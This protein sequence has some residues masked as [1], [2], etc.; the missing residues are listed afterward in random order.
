MLPTFRSAVRRKLL[1]WYEKDKRDLPWRRKV[2]PYAVWIAETMLQQ[3]QVKTV[4]P[5]YAKFLQ[6]FPTAESLARA[7]LQRVMRHWSG[8]GY[9]RRAENL[10]KAARQIVRRHRGKIPN[11]YDR[12]RA[13]PGIGD[14]TAGAVLSIAFDRRYPAIDGN[15][16][17][18]L[19]RLVRIENE[20]E[21]RALGAAL[22]PRTGPGRFNQALMELGATLCTPRNPRC[23]ACPLNSLCA[24]RSGAQTS[25]EGSERT[26]TKF[27][28]VTWPLALVRRGGKI[29]LRRRAG[30]GLLAGLWD[31]PGGQLSRRERIATLLQDHLVE[32]KLAGTPPM[33]IGEIRHAITYRR[34][35]API[36]LVNFEPDAEVDLP[37]SR[38]RWIDPAK[39][40]KQAISSMTA[41][42]VALFANYEK[43]SH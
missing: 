23:R 34:I 6:A 32:L 26:A 19:R 25:G 33:K 40:Q 5:Y 2:D 30:R 18:V 24:S 35:R 38:W 16:Q 43:N 3:T 39:L 41:K 29:L 28:N 22:V 14:Y 17:R 36:Y 31:L 9:Y 8:L 13:L 12:L 1:R 37:A 4:I 15:A 7:P 42:A 20:R 27:K 11:D 10:S 21:L